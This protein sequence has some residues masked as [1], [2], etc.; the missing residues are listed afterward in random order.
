MLIFS[1]LLM[2]LDV[3][4]S[5]G[6]TF[7][8]KV[9]YESYYPF[10][11]GFTWVFRSIIN[12]SDRYVFLINLEE[13]NRNLQKEVHYLKKQ[14]E[15]EQE[16]SKENLRLRSMLDF[17]YG[18]RMDLISSDVICHDSTTHFASIFIN[19]GSKDGIS[20]NM[21]VITDIGVVGKV[22]K[23]SYRVSQVQTI[24]DK[25][26][27]ISVKFKRTGDEGIVKG[28]GKDYLIMD[29][30]QGES[31]IQIGDKLY[32]SGYGSIYPGDMEIGTVSEI[33]RE[34]QKM[35]KTLIIHPS[36]KIEKVREVFVIRDKNFEEIRDI[37][38]ES[39]K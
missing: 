15:L 9:I 27:R 38:G 1:F 31:S 25:M 35:T 17:S 24:A 8:E 5:E 11:Q 12:I 26:S 10:Q 32:T 7:L 4:V 30:V 3:Q 13:E 29:F 37:L 2:T 28:S 39:A 18:A 33:K 36:E 23:V 20:Y 21:P 19:R 14:L 22:I 16:S 6:T 34:F